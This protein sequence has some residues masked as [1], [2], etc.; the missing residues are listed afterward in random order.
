MSHGFVNC[1]LAYY[2]RPINGFRFNYFP[3]ERGV[4]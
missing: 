4:K 2:S 1:K 3:P